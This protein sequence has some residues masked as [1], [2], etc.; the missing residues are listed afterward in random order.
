MN[1]R[2]KKFLLFFIILNAFFL[3]MTEKC[4]AGTE[5]TDINSIDDSKYPGIKAKIQALQAQ[6]P[7]WTFKVEET[8]L[9]FEEVI[10]GEHQNHGATNDPVNLVPISNSYAG[11]W[12]CEIDGTEKCDS[13]SWYCASTEALQYMMDPRNSINATDV[14]QFLQLSATDDYTANETVRECLK[15]MAQSAGMRYIDDECIEAIL[16]AATTYH[17]D[18]Y[19]IMSKIMDEQGTNKDSTPLISGAGYNGNYVGYYNFFN[20]GA[21]SNTGTSSGVIQNGLA[22]A[23]SQGWTS[24]TISIVEGTRLIAQNYIA[25]EQDTLYYQKFNVVG[26]NLYNHQ[27]QQNILAAQNGGT[28]LMKLYKTFDSQ[29]KNGNYTFIIPLYTNMPENACSRPSVTSS[30]TLTSNI[31]MGDVNVDGKVNLQDVIILLN[32]LKGERTL[33][34]TGLIAARVKGNSTA[35]LGDVIL[36]LNY[37]KGTAVL[38]ASGMQTGTLTANSNLRLSP[39]G[40]VYSNLSTG[41]SIKIISL[42]TEQVNGYYWDLVVTSKGLYGYIARSNY[43]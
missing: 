41:T 17:V 31:L 33:E 36:I 8:G 32:Y 10:N 24:K 13:G 29:L 3:F 15:S 35:G 42:A 1:K 38:P 6:Y 19:Y 34:G 22:Y 7:N 20:I 2:I 5:I 26:S 37:L 11:L 28:Y 14:F 18:P 39:N 43:Q 21:T 23:A 12:I 9:S 16:Q 40:S 30:H 25:K 27:Y 4:F